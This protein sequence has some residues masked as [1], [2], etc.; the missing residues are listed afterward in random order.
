G[1]V[2]DDLVPVE[3]SGAHRGVLPLPVSVTARPR[4]VLDV[5]VAQMTAEP[6][7]REARREV[8][9]DCHV[10]RVID[11]A[12]ALWRMLLDQQ[13]GELG[14]RDRKSTRLNSSHRTISYA[15]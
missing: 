10:A 8:A 6:G 5:Y 3:H 2:R 7:D 14:P 12:R 13:R 15:V 1:E 9:L 4:D 11:D